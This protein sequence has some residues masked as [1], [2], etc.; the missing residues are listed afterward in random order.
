MKKEKSASAKLDQLQNL[1]EELCKKKPNRT[2]LKQL[3][4]ALGN[5]PFSTNEELMEKI[6]LS[7][8]S[9]IKNSPQPRKETEIYK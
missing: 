5:L 8:P 9:I 6:L 1:V 4:E 3:A 7:Y 2:K